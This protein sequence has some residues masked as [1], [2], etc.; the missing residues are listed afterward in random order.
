MLNFFAI[1]LFS[2]LVMITLPFH[3]SVSC[4]PWQIGHLSESSINIL[5]FLH[6]FFLF[7]IFNNILIYF[8]KNHH[9]MIFSIIF[10]LQFL[11]HKNNMI[12]LTIIYFLFDFSFLPFLSFFSDATSAFAALS[13]I[14]FCLCFSSC[15]HSIF[16]NPGWR[17][18]KPIFG[19]EV[20]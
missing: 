2:G 7:A 16:P 11:T 19:C 4:V 15:I 18:V 14:T 5:H 3:E 17:I 1:S 6:T 12:L 13:D 20:L 9:K 10:L 8:M